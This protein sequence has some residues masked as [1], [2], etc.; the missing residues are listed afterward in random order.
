MDSRR[1]IALRGSPWVAGT[2]DEPVS[3]GGTVGGGLTFG[4]L[5]DAENLTLSLV[6]CLARAQFKL[7]ISIN[8]D[9]S[10]RVYFFIRLACNSQL[11]ALKKNFLQRGPWPF[12]QSVILLGTLRVVGK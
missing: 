2:V 8:M 11:K 1:F 7:Q 3:A 10:T 12:L 4:D 6:A 9:K 5:E